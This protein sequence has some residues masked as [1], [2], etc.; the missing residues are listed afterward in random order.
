MPQP[1]LSPD[2][3]E[4]RFTVV[5]VCLAEGY[6]PPGR[7]D[8]LSKGSAIREAARR[9]QMDPHTLR[10]STLS[11]ARPRDVD[12]G[13]FDWWRRDTLGA[14]PEAPHAAPK[15]AVTPEPIDL[16][17][18]EAK[19]IRRLE[20]EVSD[21]RRELK[22]T[23]ERADR[24]EEVREGLFKLQDIPSS[25]KQ[26]KPTLNNNGKTQLDVILFTSDAQVGE[27]IRSGE[28]DSCNEY[29]MDI[30]AERYATLI[31]KTINLS[32]LY[33]GDAEFGTA[34]YLRGGDAVSGI[35]HFELE[36]TNDLSALPAV[37]W[38][39]QHE[40]EGIRRLAD[41]FG[42]VQVYSISGNHGRYDLKSPSKSYMSRNFETFLALWLQSTFRNDPRITWN[43]PE[44]GFAYFE[45]RGWRF[46]LA[47]GDRMGSRGGTGFIGPIATIAR[48]HQRLMSNW[49]M[50]GKPIDYVLTGHLHTSVRTEWG[51]GN[52]SFPGFNE[53]ARDLQMTP[54]APKQWMFH[55]HEKYGVSLAVEIQL[56]EKPKRFITPT[57]ALFR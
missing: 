17:S 24:A 11:T 16:H 22:R 29:N 36:R 12:W 33:G 30:F 4:T 14:L 38:L 39:L 19:K 46:L 52:G 1:T 8:P 28:M 5:E 48:G 3:F 15:T 26:W 18:D 56:A 37:Q 47:H 41:K 49:A 44:S 25:P 20:G 42:R 13:I 21:L 43:T 9:L 35:I 27:V 40:A 51:Y 6:E 45:S 50:T 55:V 10:N 57:P 7:N 32:G 2:E 54:D 23:L 31:D 53:F 34:Y